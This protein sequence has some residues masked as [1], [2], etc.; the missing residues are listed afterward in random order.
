MVGGWAED[1]QVYLRGLLFDT[2]LVS[3]NRN[4]TTIEAVTA[5]LVVVADTA[6]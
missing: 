6:A 4:R 5:T 3:C 2:E 1:S